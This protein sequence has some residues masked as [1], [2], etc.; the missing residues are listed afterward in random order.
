VVAPPEAGAPAAAQG[1][2]AA[3]PPASDNIFIYPRDGQS[4]DRQARDRY[5]CHR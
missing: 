4:A 2:G 3:A 1:Y 5:D